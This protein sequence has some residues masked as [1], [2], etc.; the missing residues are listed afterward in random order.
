VTNDESPHKY[1]VKVLDP[2]SLLCF[3]N[4]GGYIS[5]LSQRHNVLKEAA[6]QIILNIILY[7]AL[8]G[9]LYVNAMEKDWWL[10]FVIVFVI[11]VSVVVSLL[12]GYHASRVS[13]GDY[14][15]ED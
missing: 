7:G 13:P 8:L 2:P 3:G 11:V 5:G 15:Y 14:P 9:W 1:H 4:C 6:M 12:P 10:C